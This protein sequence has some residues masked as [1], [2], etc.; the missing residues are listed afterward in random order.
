MELKYCNKILLAKYFK[1]IEQLYSG[2]QYYRSS[3]TPLMKFLLSEKSKF[4]N[5]KVIKPFLIFEKD[6]IVAVGT[7]IWVKKYPHILQIAFFETHENNEVIELIIDVAKNMC[8]K[9]KAK[10]IV[11]GM[12]GHMSNGFGILCNAY[13]QDVSFGGSY[14]PRYYE[15]Y[16]SQVASSTMTVRTYTANIENLEQ[17]ISTELIGNVF[18]QYTFRKANLK[19]LR[20]EI[21]QYTHLSNYCFKNHPLYYE[22]TFEEDYEMFKLFRLFLKGENLLF[23]EKHGK[24]V[25]FLLWYPN[26]NEIVSPGRS[27]GPLSLIKFKMFPGKIKQ[28]QGVQIGVLPK[29]QRKG[30]GFGLMLYNYKIAKKRFKYCESGWVEDSNIK[31]KNI[32]EKMTINKYNTGKIYKIFQIDI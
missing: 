12:N 2:N 18:D 9:Y 25:G 31:S 28:F 23:A 10:H 20:S 11:F 30:I 21:E 5:D 22:R 1:F 13:N 17:N 14:N 4:K 19:N 6:Q 16:L 29:Y 3:T 15:K 32:I 24:P 7:Y 27:L 8:E 26:F